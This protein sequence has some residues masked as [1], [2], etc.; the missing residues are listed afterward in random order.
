[1]GENVIISNKH[2]KFKTPHEL[3]KDLANT[4]KRE[5]ATFS[6]D[7]Y[8]NSWATDNIDVGFKANV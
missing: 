4:S 6:V 7:L 3:L 8:F 5:L 1:M 2:G